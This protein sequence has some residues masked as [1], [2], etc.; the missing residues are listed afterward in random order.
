[1]STM[2]LTVALIEINGEWKNRS[3]PDTIRASTILEAF[4]WTSGIKLQTTERIS[5]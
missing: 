4:I 1:M 5:D 3:I 2:Q